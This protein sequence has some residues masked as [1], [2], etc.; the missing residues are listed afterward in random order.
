MCSVGWFYSDELHLHSAFLRE[1]EREEGKINEYNF[2]DHNF[3]SVSCYCEGSSEKDKMN[4]LSLLINSVQK[5]RHSRI[6]KDA[7]I[8]IVQAH[9]LQTTCNIPSMCIR[10]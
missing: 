8:Q 9:N 10:K 4:E 5:V 2:L 7:V 6:I 3:L 1:S